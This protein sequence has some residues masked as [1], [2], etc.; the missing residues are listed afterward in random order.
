M[1]LLRAALLTMLVL[2]CCPSLSAMG[3]AK[4]K[5]IASFHLETDENMNPKMTFSQMTNGKVRFFRRMPEIST[6]DIVSFAPFS[7]DNGA[8]NG[9]IFQL[10]DN[11]AKRLAAVTNMN[12]GR[13]LLAQI[14]GRVIDAVLIDKPVTDGFIIVWKEITLEDVALFDESIPRINEENNK[15]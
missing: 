3:K 8:A 14:N 1:Q 2:V 15:K 5:F 12:Q 11:A 4:H 6:I 9:V 7:S 10:K 13:W